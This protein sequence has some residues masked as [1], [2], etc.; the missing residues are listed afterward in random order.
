M[1]LWWAIYTVEH[2]ETHP[3]DTAILINTQWRYVL[4]LLQILK[5][6]RFS[7]G[8]FQSF[9]LG[10]FRCV[11]LLWLCADQFS[12]VINFAF[13]LTSKILGFLKKKN[14]KIFRITLGLP[15]SYTG[16]TVS[17]FGECNFAKVEKI[18]KFRLTF[19]Q[20]GKL[21]YS[22]YSCF[23]TF[24]ELLR[25]WRFFRIPTKFPFF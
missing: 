18:K 5:Y 9:L 2:N 12:A 11:K 23:S 7:L 16:H 20:I 19:L 15:I 6:F 14:E 3:S 25:S 4:L 13:N 22:G 24:E 8:N 10:G 17:T 1:L 21:E